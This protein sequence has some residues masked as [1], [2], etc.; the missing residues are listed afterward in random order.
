MKSHRIIAA[1]ATLALAATP[2]ALAKKDGE[3]HG[4][5]KE[6]SALKGQNGKGKNKAKSVTLKGAVVS[7]DTAG[8]VVMVTKANKHGRHLVGTEQTFTATKVNVADTNGDLAYTTDDIAD[9]DK[10]VVQAR[11]AKDATAPYAARHIVDQ[12]N[13]KPEDEE[14]EEAEEAEAAPVVPA[15]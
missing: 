4:K 7:A 10:V 12:T 8:V 3:S 5:G 14:V 1:A 13:P 6:K 11:I 2:V 15:A 9:G